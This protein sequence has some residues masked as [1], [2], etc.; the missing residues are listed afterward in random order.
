M[1]NLEDLKG[2]TEQKGYLRYS[3]DV[4]HPH[5][6]AAQKLINL[7]IN[8]FDVAFEKARN[9][10]QVIWHNAP[11]RPLIYACDTIPLD[12]ADLGRYGN[13][14]YIAEAERFFQIPAETCAMV[15]AVAGGLYQ[16]KDEKITKIVDN[17]LRCEPE[18]TILST[19]DGYGYDCFMME[20]YQRPLDNDEKRIRL[21]EQAYRN[22]YERI[23][24]W[25]TGRDIDKEKLREELVRTNRIRSKVRQLLE[26]EKKHNTYYRTIPTFL[27]YN[28]VDSYYGQPE[29]YENIIDEM[30]EEI[31]TLS[32]GEYHDE[33]LVKLIWS[34]A[35]GVDF[36]VYNTV[37]IAGGTIA[38]WNLPANL[39]S[40]Y[41]TSIDPVDALVQFEVKSGRSNNMEEAC[42]FDADLAQS[43]GAKGEILFLTLGCTLLTVPSEMKRVHL[44]HIGIPTLSLAGTAQIGEITGQTMTRLK[45]FIEMLSE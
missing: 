3:R 19:L 4:I 21:V 12:L 10:K 33:S 16:Y 31:S 18:I 22:E 43:V 9:G 39:Y 42:Q 2:V 14:A 27:A 24:K 36:S 20:T 40:D 34:G 17:G 5:S 11:G 25:L 15:K 6:V 32:E 44:N 37:D 26:I 1:F 35:R 8:H 45:A 23:A 41:D 29:E 7:V 13:D 28:G 38:G 30:I